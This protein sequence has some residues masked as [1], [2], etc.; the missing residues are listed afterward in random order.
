MYVYIFFVRL[1]TRT[2]DFQTREEI[3]QR[4]IKHIKIDFQKPNH[5]YCY[6]PTETK[7]WIEKLSDGTVK[8][9]VIP[10]PTGVGPYCDNITNTTTSAIGNT[11]IIHEDNGDNLIDPIHINRNMTI[12][13]ASYPF[14]YTRQI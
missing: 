11:E 6:Q 14:A 12:N 13:R 10:G 4:E 3:P 8:A 5:N 2:E 1:S 7:S 9:L